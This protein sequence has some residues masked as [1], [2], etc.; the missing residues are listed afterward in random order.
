MFDLEL[1]AQLYAL[2]TDPAASPE[3][4][5][6][7][8]QKIAQITDTVVAEYLSSF[9]HE[10]DGG[11][12]FLGRKK[13]TRKFES[14][15]VLWARNCLEGRYVYGH[16]GIDECPPVEDKVGNVLFHRRYTQRS[17]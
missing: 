5:E 8:K 10:T 11:G 15:E 13:G 12:A 9:V 17:E 3:E 6:E 2:Q 7:A 16:G 1:V 14:Y 4:R